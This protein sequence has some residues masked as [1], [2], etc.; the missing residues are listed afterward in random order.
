MSANHSDPS[1]PRRLTDQEII[2]VH[3]HAGEEKTD[4]GGNYKL[5]PLV[6]LFVFSG[7]IFF[8][9]TY[10]GMF[11]GHF[12]PTVHDERG[13]PMAA[14][15]EAKVDVVALGKRQYATCAGCHQP[16]GMGLPS[17]FPPL[18]KSEFVLGSEERL[19][20][21]LLNGLNGPITVA[22]QQ[23][24][25][26]PGATAMPAFGSGPGGLAWSDDNIAAVLTY[27]RQEW[28]NSAPAITAAKVAEIRAKV[29]TR[30]NWTA[31]EL[32]AFK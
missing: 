27:I 3:D 26:G 4:D 28:G 10:I 24:G 7:L 9:G 17:L 25:A 19:V 5:L 32:E 18:A 30:G 22:G 31:A 1:D 23:F 16:T 15:T 11:S 29:G 12:A 14:V 2:Q 8:G 13:T 21:I 20:R 6:M